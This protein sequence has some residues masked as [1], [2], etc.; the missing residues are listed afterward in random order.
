MT[1]TVSIIV[2]VHNAEA[3]LQECVD[4]VIAQSSTDWELILVDDGSTDSSSRMCDDFAAIDPRIKV[5]HKENGG[6]SSARNMGLDMANGRYYVFIDADDAI[7]PRFL[8]LMTSM[9]ADA[10]ADIGISRYRHVSSFKFVPIDKPLVYK[11]VEPIKAIESTLY[12]NGYDNSVS[13][14]IFSAKLFAGI[15]FSNCRF[16][17]LDI[18][19]RIYERA[20]RIAVTKETL[21]FYR[22]HRDSFMTAWSDD[23]C[24]VIGVVDKM[25]KHVNSMHP[26]L[27]SAVIDRKFS[28]CFN[29]FINLC[30]HDGDPDMI[31]RCW[32]TITDYRRSVLG[33]K[34]SRIKN[35]IGALV[36]YFGRSFVLFLAQCNTK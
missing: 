28:A 23:R 6:P 24:D 9:I 1:P 20:S 11:S 30:R 16:E 4:S 27:V 18:F 13:A 7:N 33:N 10:G 8:G 31:D 22:K 19:Y 35:R 2:P 17:D 15:R 32:S 3:Y 34:K 21:Y 36:S 5:V 12:Q 29:I 14:K 26:E 25:E